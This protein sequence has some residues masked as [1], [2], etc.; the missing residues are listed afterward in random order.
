MAN[1]ILPQ[2]KVLNTISD[3]ATMLVEENGE[4]RRYNVTSLTED[5]VSQVDNKPKAGFI[6]PLATPAV[7]EG[8]LLCDGTAYSR[9][10]YSE[11]FAAIGT[12]YGTGDGSTTF[13]VP[14]LATRVPVGKG[15]GYALGATGGEE[16]HT[17]TIDEMPNHQHDIRSGNGTSGSGLCAT[18]PGASGTDGNNWCFTDIGVDATANVSGNFM[19]TFNGGSQPHNNMQPYTVVNY[20]IATGKDTGVS[21]QDVIAGAQALPLGV[22]YGGTGATNAATALKNLGGMST[23][24]LWE[25]ARPNNEF[26]AQTINLPNNGIEAFSILLGQTS[27]EVIGYITIPIGNKYVFNC[28]CGSLT[29]Q[30]GAHAMLSREMRT[31]QNSIYFEQCFANGDLFNWLQVNHNVIPFKIYGVKGVF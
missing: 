31:T 3:S 13:N 9:T 28:P 25:N 7:P 29:M 20:I 16:K 26:P 8:F 17:L 10:E 5:F 27:G 14:N 1:I 23:E 4:I 12:I 24:L 22:E 2:A 6:Y 19:T 18:S 15:S 30:N 11:L 21:I